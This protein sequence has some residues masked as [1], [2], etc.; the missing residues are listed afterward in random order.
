[1]LAC[2][3]VSGLLPGFAHWW[4]KPEGAAAAIPADIGTV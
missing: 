2:T 1:M 4:N 3:M